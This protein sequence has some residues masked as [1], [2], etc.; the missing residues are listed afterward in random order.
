MSTQDTMPDDA[1]QLNLLIEWAADKSIRQ[2]ILPDNL[3]TLY[4]F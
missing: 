3:A 4:D 2:R 1:Q